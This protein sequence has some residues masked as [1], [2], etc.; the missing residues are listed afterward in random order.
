MVYLEA[1]SVGLAV[2]GPA[3]GGVAE[4]IDHGRTGLLVPPGDTKALAAAARDL[5]CNPERRRALGAAARREIELRFSTERGIDQIQSVYK[6]TC[7]RV[8]P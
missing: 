1:M 2:V 3:G 4:V 6:A 8:E 5:L 7:A